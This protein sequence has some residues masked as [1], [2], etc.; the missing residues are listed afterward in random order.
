MSQKNI[1]AG[2]MNEHVLVCLSASPSN[3]K[4]I[5]E[6][7]KLAKA[8]NAEFTALHVLKS[9]EDKLSSIDQARLQNNIR[10]AEDK[11]AAITNW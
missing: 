1:S 10:Y 7:A 5:D 11:G 2:V 4:V 8:F 6:A 9:Q 3:Q